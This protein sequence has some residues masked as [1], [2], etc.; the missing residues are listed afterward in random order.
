[1]EAGCESRMLARDF[2]TSGLGV[3]VS[4]TGL[5]CKEENGVSQFYCANDFL[6]IE[7]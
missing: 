3:T 1:M 4:M 2:G 6:I 7:A 5:G